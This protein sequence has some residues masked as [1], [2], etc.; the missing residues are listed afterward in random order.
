MKFPLWNRCYLIKSKQKC[1]C[2]TTFM[3]IQACLKSSVAWATVSLSWYYLLSNATDFVSGDSKRQWWRKIFPLIF[4][5]ISGCS[6]QTKG[7]SP[8]YA[9]LCAMA[10]GLATKNKAGRKIRSDWLIS[11]WTFL[12]GQ[13][14][15]IPMKIPSLNVYC[16]AYSE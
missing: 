14:G 11:E 12:N 16:K 2:T 13:C 15:D 9:N 4:N 6:S 5:K 8:R 10:N 1:M 3:M 7:A